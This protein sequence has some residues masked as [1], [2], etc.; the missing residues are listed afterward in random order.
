MPSQDFVYDLTE[1]LE[2]DNIEFAVCIL[3]HGKKKSQIDMHL[4]LKT[5]ESVDLVCKTFNS[6]CNEEDDEDLDIDYP[7][8]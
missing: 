5:E 4:N 7:D 3:R 1:K 6:I 2:E 8:E